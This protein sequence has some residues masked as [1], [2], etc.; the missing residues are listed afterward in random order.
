M[1]VSFSRA[2]SALPV[3]GPA[4]QDMHDIEVMWETARQAHTHV[5]D[6]GVCLCGCGIIPSNSSS[7]FD[8]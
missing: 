8:T 5:V 2:L 1:H 4:A 7:D 3:D 6:L